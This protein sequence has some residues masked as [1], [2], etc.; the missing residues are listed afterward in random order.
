MTLSQTTASLKVVGETLT[1]TA[2]VAP[3]NATFKNVTWSSSNTA[4]ATVADGVVTAKASVG[5]AIITVKTADGAKTATC[6]VTVG[7]P[8]TGVT[9]SQTSASLKVGETLTL[10]ATV[11]PDNAT[12]KSV[13]WSSSNTAVA[14]VSDGKVTAK[15]A[16]TATITVKTNDG[17]KTATCTVIVFSN[18]TNTVDLSTITS[19]YTSYGDVLSGTLKANVKISIA[20]GATVTLDGVNINGSGTW[21][22]G[23]Y[24][25]INCEGNAIII[26]KGSNTVKGF[27]RVY[28]G[29][30]VPEGKTVT[31]KG[32]GSLTASS[33]G[34]A[35][36]I[37]GGGEFG[38][39]NPSCGNIVIEGGNI[40][41]TGGYNAAGIGGGGYSSCGNITI[42]GGTVNAKGG[43]Y[44]AGIGG[45]RGGSCGN[46]TITDG[47]TSVSATKGKGYSAY[48]IGA[49]HQGS[50]GTV[51]IGGKT[52]AISTSPYTYKP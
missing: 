23:N 51:T 28:P 39:G 10:K 20:D 1:L 7:V 18:G 15:A 24:A 25:G 37:G 11:A 14:T 38:N 6:T 19:N 50:C 32:D 9:L 29:I 16:G 35:A 31:I 22:G 21:T 12:D 43:D 3:S 26:L 33:N 5:T 49:G 46:I 8:V 44:G 13:T 52:G 17:A 45:G 48:S 4:V 41:A 2:T 34:N 40:T 42:K 47:V 30:H 27:Y 36:G